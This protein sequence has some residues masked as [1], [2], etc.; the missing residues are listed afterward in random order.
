VE[1]CNMLI[2]TSLIFSHSYNEKWIFDDIECFML[3]FGTI[4]SL[5]AICRHCAVSAG[6]SVWRSIEFL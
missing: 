3:R 1:V 5:Q 6:T 2:D 4:E